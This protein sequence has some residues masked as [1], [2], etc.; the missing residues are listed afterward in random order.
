MYRPAIFI[1]KQID[2]NLNYINL[3][4]ILFFVLNRKDYYFYY[5]STLFCI[6][7]TFKSHFLFFIKCMNEDKKFRK[8][9]ILLL[10]NLNSINLY[11]T[12]GPHHS[13]AR[14]NQVKNWNRC[15]LFALKIYNVNGTV[16]TPPDN[17][18]PRQ[19]GYKRA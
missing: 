10:N 14:K 4:I 16:S 12:S 8:R 18:I 1:S 7:Y 15:K 5:H 13:F 11:S 9:F 19:K 2:F 3:F 6:F 17:G